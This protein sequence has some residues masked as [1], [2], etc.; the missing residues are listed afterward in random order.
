MTLVLGIDGGGTK[1][2]ALLADPSGAVA[3]VGRDGPSNWETVG[4][5]GAIRTLRA[6]TDR[7]LAQAG[8]GPRDVGAATFGLGGIDW[9]SDVER[10]S[11]ELAPLG[12]PVTAE[13]VNDAFVALSAGTERP[14]GVA[15][16]A[17]TGTVAAGRDPNGRTFR[18]LGLGHEFGDYGDSTD[19]S[20]AALA[21]VAR[22]YTGMGEPTALTDALLRATG[23]SG[24]E[25]ML[26]GFSRDGLRLPQAGPLVVL[27]ADQGDRVAVEI[28]A[29]VGRSLGLAAAAVARRLG[30]EMLEFEVVL[31]GGLFMGGNHHLRDALWAELAGTAPRARL[32]KLEVPPVVGAAVMALERL[33]AEVTPEIRARLA[34]GAARSLAPAATG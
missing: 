34:E 30:L 26:E 10:L 23:A 9:P 8:A 2:H 33:G 7:A 16:V 6:V 14:W 3:G 21:A 17:G 12:L 29:R 20:N 28:M 11:P 32:V 24:V 25:E 5:E 19:M 4:L 1:T 22:A 15:V 31:S 27:A 18:T 13:L